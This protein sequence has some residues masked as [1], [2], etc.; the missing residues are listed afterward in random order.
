MRTKAAHRQL[1]L[2]PAD[3]DLPDHAQGHGVQVR[4]DAMAL[5]RPRQWGA[6]WVACE[7]YAQLELDRFWAGRLSDSREGTSWRHTLQTLGRYRL[8]DL[9]SEWRLHRQRFEQNDGG[10]A[11][12]RRRSGRDECALPLTGPAA[13]SKEALFLH[14]RQRWADLFGATFEVLLHDQPAPISIYPRWRIITTSAAMVI[15]ATSAAIAC[16]W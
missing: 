8:I 1:A 13:P 16:R 11:R 7:L 3:R 4:L 14:L 15:A 10:P 12:R 6:C 2:F 5:H 9:G